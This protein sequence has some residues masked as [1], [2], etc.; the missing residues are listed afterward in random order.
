MRILPINI[1]SPMLAK[2]NTNNNN[3]SIS[4]YMQKDVISFSGKHVTQ[5]LLDS[6]LDILK[7]MKKM[8]T[9]K[10][11]AKSQIIERT[12]K[13]LDNVNS[14]IKP[15]LNDDDFLWN[16]TP[17]SKKNK[18]S[19]IIVSYSMENGINKENNTEIMSLVTSLMQKRILGENSKT[20]LKEFEDIEQKFTKPEQQK[21]LQQ[22]KD[23][24]LKKLEIINSK[25]EKIN[26]IEMEALN[27]E[28][29]NLLE[30]AIYKNYLTANVDRE[31]FNRELV[32]RAIQKNPSLKEIYSNS[33][34]KNFNKIKEIYKKGEASQLASAR[35]N[36]DI[37][38]YLSSGYLYDLSF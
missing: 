12:N 27:N 38:R 15:L 29:R 7:R 30:Q 5:S 35:A 2:N 22:L 31:T 3:F 8:T 26:T 24:I 4:S 23:Y 32:K 16:I 10:D 36:E 13:L 17:E 25:E 21:K 37:I 34:K 33:Y 19:A 14:K 28:E 20:L 1:A 6:H 11:S 9:L 18:F